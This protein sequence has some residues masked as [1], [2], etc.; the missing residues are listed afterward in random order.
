MNPKVNEFVKRAAIELQTVRENKK[1]NARS[2]EAFT[3]VLFDIN[4]HEIVKNAALDYLR[5]IKS[6]KSKKAA[7]IIARYAKYLK[8]MKKIEKHL[9]EHGKKIVDFVAK[10][11]YLDEGFQFNFLFFFNQI[12]LIN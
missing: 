3:R 5:S 10:A 11:K 1:S 7:K 6:N 8:G 12:I 4:Q 9:P 2:I